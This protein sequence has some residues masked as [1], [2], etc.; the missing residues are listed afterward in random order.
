MVLEVLAI[1]IKK[2]SIQIGR[3]E[4][5]LSL[6]ADDTILYLENP[7]DSTKK[8]TRTDKFSMVA[9]YK[10]NIQK[11][12]AFL[13]TNNEISERECEKPDT[14]KIAFQKIKY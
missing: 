6:Y 5:K 10:I 8:T 7:Q 11:L 12:V 2:K 14:F 4:V 9:E 3:E 13:Y 1:A